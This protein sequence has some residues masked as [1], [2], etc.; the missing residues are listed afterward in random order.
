MTNYREDYKKEVRFTRAELLKFRPIKLPKV[1]Y[2][3]TGGPFDTVPVDCW[4]VLQNQNGTTGQ[5][6]CSSRMGQFLKRIVNGETRSYESWYWMLY[7]SIR[8]CG[9]SS[10][11][12]VEL[13]RLD[14]VFHDMMAKEKNLP[15]HRFLGADRDWTNVYASGCGTNLTERELEKEVASFIDEGYTTF[16]MKIA[17]RFGTQTDKDVERVRIVRSLIGENAKLALDANQLWKAEEAVRFADKVKKYDIAW[18]EE[19]VH[20]YDMTELKKLAPISPIPLAMGESPRCYYPMESYVWAG[21]SQLQPIPSNLSSVEDWMR[22]KQ[23]AY[24]NNLELTSGGYSHLTASFIAAGREEDM[25]EYLIPV[26]RP[27]WEIMDVRP[28]EQGGRFYL[29]E[30]P[31]ISMSPDIPGLERAGMISSK[32]YYSDR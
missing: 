30:E 10:E 32:E 24:E 4:L 15:L 13:G 28:Q 12:A 7:W 23:L 20:S 19:P 9:F 22:T 27:F 1:F 18:F 2:D 3:S 29:P 8:N 6:P 31:G 17:A 26:M 25:V 11:A 5:C 16:K 14:L 21:V